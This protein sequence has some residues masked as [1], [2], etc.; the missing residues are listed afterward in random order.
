[1]LKDFSLMCLELN[2]DLY[3]VWYLAAELQY[4]FEASF[5]D[6]LDEKP[7]INFFFFISLV[8]IEEVSPD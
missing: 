4:Y 7:S 1:M 6:F 3:I 2:L 8:F 5:A